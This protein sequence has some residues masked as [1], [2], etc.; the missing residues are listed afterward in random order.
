MDNVE[1]L[2]LINWKELIVNKHTW[3]E[4][5]L[6][7]HPS[8]THAKIVSRIFTIPFSGVIQ[9]HHHLVESMADAI[10]HYVFD[11]ETLDKMK[12]E[13]VVPFRKAAQ[14]FGDTNPVKDGKYGELLLYILSEAILST[15]MVSHKIT[16]LSNLNDQVKGGDGV[17]FGV[18]RDNLSI[19]IGESKIYKS[20]SG[21]LESAF[22]SLDRFTKSY[23]SGAL[24]HELFMARTNISNNFDFETMELIYRAFT[25]GD[26]IYSE[27]VK[28]HPVLL[29][30]ED[31]E[32][33]VIEENS[34]TKVDAENALDAWLTT[35]KIAIKA[36]IDERLTKYP[37]VR[38]CFLDFFLIPMSD[39]GEFKKSLYRAIHAIDYKEN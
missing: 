32:I 34:V 6:V 31:R 4:S 10:E 23:T 30:F 1:K 5:R 13:G 33:K 21:A 11:K 16:S 7:N 8:D 26:D 9:E 28:T 24:G 27:C 29:I 39:V 20:F 2:K 38:P 12:A 37:N 15:P 19:L 36:A 22:D 25:P 17:F 35:K 3:I 18:Y 14:F